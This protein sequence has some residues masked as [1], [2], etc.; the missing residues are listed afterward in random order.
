M[1]KEMSSLTVGREFQL[2]E[3]RVSHGMLLIRSPQSVTHAQN[4]DVT[5]AGVQYVALPR[6]LG[7]ISIA[8]E[9]SPEQLIAL[10]LLLGREP[11]SSDKIFVVRALSN[12]YIVI[13]ANCMIRLTDHDLFETGF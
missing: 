3:Y 2:W 9:R 10:G 5:F 4:C 8:E 12:D 7:S 11:Y 1:K 13:A 6:H